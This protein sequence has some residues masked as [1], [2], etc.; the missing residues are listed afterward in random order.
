MKNGGTQ[1]IYYGWWIAVASF[2]IIFFGAGIAFYSFTVFVKPLEAQFGWTRA[3]ISAAIAVWAL[4]YGFTGPVVGVL[5]H[6]YGARVVIAGSALITGVCYLLFGGLQNLPQLFVLMFLAGLGSAGITLIPNQTLISNWFEQYRGRAMGIMM[7]G[8]GLGGLT[9]PPVANAIITWFGWRTSFR[10]LGLILIFA[11]IPIALLVVRTKP[12]DMGL[13]ADGKGSK[14]GD[15]ATP[16]AG[17]N[18][19]ASGLPVKRALGT[20]S[21]WMLF[22]AFMLLIFGESGLVVH[23]VPLIDDAGLPS[24]TAANFWGLAVGISAAGRLGFGFFADRWNPRNLIAVTHGLHAVA[25][26]II[27]VFFLHMGTRS[28]V[29]LLPFSVLYGLSLGGSAVL[30]PVLVGRCFGLLNFGKLL[31]LLMSGFAL[32][33][34]GGPVVAG[35]IV[36]ATGSYRLALIIFAVG[37]GLAALA[38]SF[39]QPD[40]YKE[41]FLLQ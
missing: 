25:L 40:R 27:L 10:A 34:V 41:E 22:I 35:R 1:P 20:R 19:S 15:A 32:G 37:F 13:E 6:K 14:D 3:M 4:V 28:S 38:V 39:V 12:S 23:F 5:L 26:A 8:I 18:T 29:S 30:F 16:G 2:I 9:M 11:I 36:D 24:Q 17:R 31:G 33:V 7:V 21:F